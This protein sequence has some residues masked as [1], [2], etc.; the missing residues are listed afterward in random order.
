VIRRFAIIWRKELAQHALAVA[1]MA[2]LLGLLGLVHW[3]DVHDDPMATSR[4][5]AAG[6]AL[7]MFVPIGGLILGHRLVV[8]EYHAGTQLFLEALPMRRWEFVLAKHTF[9]LAVLGALALLLLTVIA[10]AAGEGRPIPLFIAGV[11][12]LGYVAAW[13][14]VLFTLGLLGRLR[15]PTYIGLAIALYLL[16]STTA[17]EI[18]RFGPF[19]LI[20]PTTFVHERETLPTRP[21]LQTSVLTVAFLVLAL[22]LSLIREGS[23]A[24]ML[25]RRASQREKSAL[26]VLLVAA[27]MLIVVLEDKQK[28]HPFEFSSEAVRKSARDDV[29]VMYGWPEL[30]PRAVLLVE[31]LERMSQ[32]LER[33]LGIGRRPPIRV[34]HQ[35]TLD[36]HDIREERLPDADGVLLQANLG[37]QSFEAADLLQTT[38]HAS[39]GWVTGGRATHEPDHWLLDGFAGWWVAEQL[40]EARERLRLRGLV[41]ARFVDVR[42]EVIAR[43]E[44]VMETVNEQLANGLAFTAID[45]LGERHGR[46]AVIELARARFA[47]PVP[48][49]I[50]G[51]LWARDNPLE[52]RFAAV[53]NEPWSDFVRVWR[54]ELAQKSAQGPLA[55]LLRRIPQARATLRVKGGTTGAEIVYE[56]AGEA[57]A[58][59]R[60][61]VL[62]HSETRPYDQFMA[63]DRLDRQVIRWAAGER[64]VLGRLRGRYG[65]GQR[66]F[67]ALEC[68][69][70]ELGAPVRLLTVRANVP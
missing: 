35:S 3:I 24:E 36:G 58:N 14:T 70:P 59:E 56:L 15:V 40:P 22:G 31:Q 6:R 68:E 39:F 51:W 57:S 27:V 63:S 25:A 44:H 52:E 34:A 67:A 41:A 69:A 32:R 46:R 13:W 38:A 19:E 49:D 33:E 45:L 47:K 37:A 18:Q 60:E 23:V 64:R 53:T 26:T 10:F 30:E 16:Q 8:R 50:R 12:A 7:L 11:R 1:G 5:D 61:C 42:P 21:L 17:F 4:L 48:S 66:V 62:L 9:G 20:D 65:R 2:V 29:A 55:D 28:R 43:W 54:E